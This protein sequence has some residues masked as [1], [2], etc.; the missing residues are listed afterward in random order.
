MTPHAPA[1]TLE[2]FQTRA[3][4][5]HVLFDL[6]LPLAGTVLLL[7]LLAWLMQGRVAP[8]AIAVWLLC[9]AATV[10][11]RALFVHRMKAR[12]T[13]GEGHATALRGLALFSF[14]MGA[15][16]GAFA[17]MYFDPQHPLTLVILGT[18]M[19]VVIV[20][21]VLPASVYL[22]GFYLLV[23][24]AHLPYMWRLVQGGHTE[25]LVVA[26]INGMFLAVVFGYAH[27]A[28]QMH[29]DAVRLRYENK[30]LI[31]DLEQRKADA[32]SASRTKSLFLA[33]VSHDLKQPIRAIGLYTG[34]LRH[35]AAQNAAPPP[36][37]AQTAAK[38][39]AAVG[40]MHHQISRLLE[41][42]RLESGAMPLLMEALDL[43]D[44]FAHVREAQSGEAQA[45]GVQLRFAL[46][47]QRQVWADRRML[48]SILSNFVSNAIR[49]AGG[50]RVYVGTRWRP[51]HPPGQRL[52]IEVRDNGRG[53]PAHQLP[54]LFDAYRSFD[55]RQASESHG[56]GLAIARAQASYLGA[57]IAVN[58]APGRGSTFTLCGLRTAPPSAPGD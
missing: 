2:R 26:G 51:L 58:S 27:A 11:A 42:S 43:D 1:D 53:I 41:L 40:T 8:V 24:P 49:H 14:P 9:A 6:P 23:L 12:V 57:D 35:S 47:R 37:V 7:G 52:C 32:E 15:I 39:E 45:R 54:L 30:N 38:I 28:H 3:F 46:G 29:R 48:E 55:D 5:R 22:P 56:L 20:G 4:A 50:G 34:F 17:W 21:A 10:G 31:D 36:V 44:L 25:L 33:G 19:T 18:Y 13:Q 16:S